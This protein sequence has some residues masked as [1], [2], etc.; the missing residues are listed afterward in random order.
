MIRPSISRLLAVVK[1][2]ALAA[3]F[4]TALV[5]TSPE[6]LSGWQG[7]QGI[8]SV[9]T[10]IVE[11]ASQRIQDQSVSAI[12]GIQAGSEITYRDIQR[13]IKALYATGQFSDIVVR[14]RGVSPVELV[15]QVE[16]YPRIRSVQ[17]NGLESFSA[18]QV[19]DTTDLEAG[20]PVN[21]V[22][23]T[24]LTLPTKREV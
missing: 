4:F 7:Q 16:E 3:A 18:R 19:R 23:Y 20:F 6:R 5:A 8:V 2:T 24:H 11:G 21:P 1:A 13:G 10:V 22:S 14:A 9:D 12:F 15:V 17:I